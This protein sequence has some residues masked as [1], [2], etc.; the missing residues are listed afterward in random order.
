M[1]G[2][3]ALELTAFRSTRESMGFHSEMDSGA[4]TGLSLRGQSGGPVHLGVTTSAVLRLL[5]LVSLGTTWRW[6]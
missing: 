3:F 2:C 1:R 5:C 4:G 6:S